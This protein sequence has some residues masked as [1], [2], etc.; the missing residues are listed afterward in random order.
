MKR[1]D[2]SFS[3]KPKDGATQWLGFDLD[4]TLIKYKIKATQSHT[5]KCAVRYMVDTLGY[6]KW[7]LEVRAPILL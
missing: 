7:L 3:L 6:P 2:S 1:R 4:M 5:Y